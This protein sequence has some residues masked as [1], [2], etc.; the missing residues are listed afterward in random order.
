MRRLRTLFIGSAVMALAVT[1]LGAPVAATPGKGDLAIVNGVPGTTVDVCFNG[2]EVKSGLRYGKWF[3]RA[4][5]GVRKVQFFR[6]DPR[7]CKGT[8]LGTRMVTQGP[9]ADKT[10]VVTRK[11]PK[12]LVFDNE[13][14]I[15]TLAAEESMLW[16]R[17]AADLGNVWMRLKYWVI[18]TVPEQPVPPIHITPHT[19]WGKHDQVATLSPAGFI[20]RARATRPGKTKTI[21]GPKVV[22]IKKNR[23]YEWYLIGTNARNAK[24]VVFNR[25]IVPLP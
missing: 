22:A 13:G 19:K 10:L 12:V 3:A 1:S 20:W 9:T 16:W 25:K 14:V 6:A 8:K 21:A 24:M 15:D 2:T 17:H 11:T 5:N 18:L 4:F 7:K 23:R